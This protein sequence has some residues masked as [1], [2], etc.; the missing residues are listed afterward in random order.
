MLSPCGTSS[1]N[2]CGYATQIPASQPLLVLATCKCSPQELPPVL[3]NFFNTTSSTLPKA[4]ALELKSKTASNTNSSSGAFDKEPCEQAEFH[5]ASSC[6]SSSVIL[7]SSEALS[8]HSWDA[9]VTRSAQAAA[10]AVASTSVAQLQQHLTGAAIT[11]DGG[12]E[13]SELLSGTA[14]TALLN[15]I[16]G[17]SRQLEGVSGQQPSGHDRQGINGLNGQ[18]PTRH[19][20]QHGSTESVQ[21]GGGVENQAG[22]GNL[23]GERQK[24]SGHKRQLD[25]GLER[26]A[27]TGNKRQTVVN[28][29][30]MQQGLKL[31]CEVNNSSAVFRCN[32]CV[33]SSTRCFHM[34]LS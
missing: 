16:Q 10:N 7:L 28:A 30:D 34:K 13:D 21:Q 14:S 19:N 11:A 23:V 4:D 29:H 27:V 8:Q 22:L 12:S 9:A 26:Q 3:L 32:D 20:G 2:D 25:N 18:L 17:D 6:K 24:L 5:K 33:Y 15:G 31:Y 1:W